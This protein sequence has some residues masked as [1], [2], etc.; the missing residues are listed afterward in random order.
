MTRLENGSGKLLPFVGMVVAMLCQ[1]GSMVV[2][3]VAMIDDINKYV[4]VVYTFALSTILL[5]PFAF[6]LHRFSF[7][8]M[9]PNILYTFFLSKF[10][11][12]FF[13]F[14]FFCIILTPS[15]LSLLY[16]F[17]W[18]DQNVLLSRSQHLAASFCLHSL[19]WCFFF[20]LVPCFYLHLLVNY[21]ILCFIVQLFLSDSN[22]NFS[23]FYMWS[24]ISEMSDFWFRI[25]LCRSSGTIMAYV[26]IELSSPT[27]ASALLNLV[28]A[29]TFILAL[30][31]R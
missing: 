10:N 29:F 8:Y 18:V 11:N 27:L 12:F 20:L 17:H 9:E 25:L 26:G 5:L 6:F 22:F 16:P 23:F 24:F 3:K 2:I 1:S 19:G 15:S 13:F 21:Q 14:F 28:P 4:M 30:I 7:S 31:F